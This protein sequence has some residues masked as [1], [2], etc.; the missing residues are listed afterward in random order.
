M[1][2]HAMPADRARR[3]RLIGQ[4][5]EAGGVHSQEQLR[6]LL[7]DRGVDATQATISRDL[8]DI[9]VVK[10]PQGYAL[11]ADAGVATLTRDR[12]RELEEAVASDLLAAA[13]AANL[14]VLHTDPGHAQ[15]LGVAL[16]NARPEGVVGVLAGDDT[17]FLACSGAET[18][19][20]VVSRLRRTAA[21]D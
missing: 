14:A 21:L 7:L 5:I 20:R 8:R 10:G 16:D 15:A 3:T 13:A 9:G 6:E 18:A 4:F 17:I 1:Y 12:E 19:R 2:T 11:P